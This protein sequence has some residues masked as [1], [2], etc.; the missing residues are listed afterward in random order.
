MVIAFIVNMTKGYSILRA[1]LYGKYAFQI[2]IIF[3]LTIENMY[4]GYWLKCL[5]IFDKTVDM[6][7]LFFILILLC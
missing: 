2:R 3:C 7:G 5:Y 1:G 6:E 4:K